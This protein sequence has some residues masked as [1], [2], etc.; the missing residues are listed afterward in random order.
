MPVVRIRDSV[1]PTYLSNFR[2]L[3]IILAVIYLVLIC[4]TGVHHGYWN[5]LVQPLGFGSTCALTSHA[6][7]DRVLFRIFPP[8]PFPMY[9]SISLLS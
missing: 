1:A 6:F 9:M 3:Q 8:T 7:D 2:I 5:S 4:Y